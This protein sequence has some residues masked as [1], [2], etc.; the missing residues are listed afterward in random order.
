[1]TEMRRT[2]GRSGAAAIVAVTVALA[3]AAL[4]PAAGPVASTVQIL[5][6]GTDGGSYRSIGVVKADKKV[7]LAD[8]KIKFIVKR[9]GG[10]EVLDVA[11]SSDR[12]GWTSIVPVADYT[13]GG[14]DGA[15]YKLASRKVEKSGKKIRCAGDKVTAA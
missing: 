6:S 11:R 13:S 12:G 1:M 10:K 14:V 7:C 2:S 3:A 8:R 4:A 15:S 5:D 9:P